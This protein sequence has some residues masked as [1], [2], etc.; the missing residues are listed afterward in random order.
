M[1]HFTQGLNVCQQKIVVK[2]YSQIL[3]S[4]HSLLLRVY[5]QIPEARAHALIKVQTLFYNKLLISRLIFCNSKIKLTKANTITI[6]LKQRLSQI[7]R[8]C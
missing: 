4:I 6:T 1:L 2:N 3:E 5:L 8:I 7:K